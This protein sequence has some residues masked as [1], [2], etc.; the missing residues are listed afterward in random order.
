MKKK[1]L[2]ALACVLYLTG[3]SS[4]PSIEEVTDSQKEMIP[5]EFSM[6]L[7]KEVLPFPITRSIPESTIPEPSL[8]KTES[9]NL[10]LNE[11]C[12]QIEYVVFTDETVPRFIKHKHFSFDP[13]DGNMDF[14]I[15]YD[16]LKAGDYKF[17][18]LAHNSE[19]ATISGS[20]FS[21][22]NVSDSFYGALSKTIKIAEE[23]KGDIALQR[24]V[25]RIEFMA[26]DTVHTAL[27]QFNVEADGISQQLDILT[28][29]GIQTAGKKTFSHTFE[30]TEIGK[31]NTTHAFYTF[32]SETANKL[33]VHL[34]AIEKN[35]LLI[36][37]RQ[38]NNITPERNKVIH[39]KGRLY[40][41]SES[42]DTFFISIFDN[43]AWGTPQEEVLPD[44]E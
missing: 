37:E 29:N 11:L 42:D 21:F 40:S 5:I 28:G 33:S 41:R 3:C 34:A 15:V 27:K 35:D 4:N 39:Y 13:A 6:Q 8:S 10:E 38:I 36:R 18:F 32:L 16:S 43:G 17:F 22:D 31:V 30:P 7:E 25:S 44:Y 26:T 12:T 1:M 23:S 14:G 2:Y 20:T 9:N 19:T 24:I